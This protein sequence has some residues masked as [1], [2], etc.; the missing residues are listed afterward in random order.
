M[1]Q[2]SNPFLLSLAQLSNIIFLAKKLQKT[3]SC[4][5][6]LNDAKHSV[7]NQRGKEGLLR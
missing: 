6:A 7:M 5:L 3:M 1:K 2:G 4:A